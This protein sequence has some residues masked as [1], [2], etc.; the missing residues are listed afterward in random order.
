MWRCTY[1]KHVLLIFVCY[2]NL[3]NAKAECTVQ[4]KM[5]Q[6]LLGIKQLSCEGRSQVL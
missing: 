4:K 3:N 2:S 5:R 6:Y 1:E